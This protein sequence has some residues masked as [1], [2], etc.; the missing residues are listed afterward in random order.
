MQNQKDTKK[1]IYMKLS[2]ILA[3]LLAMIVISLGVI[4][5]SN[6]WNWH[7]VSNFPN[8]DMTDNK[9]LKLLGKV[10]GKSVYKYGI[11]K[12]SYQTFS[13]NKINPEDYF[14]KSWVTVDM[15]TA[16]GL[17]I[18]R[19]GYSVY[20]YE[21]YYVLNTDKA[22]VFCNNDISISEVVDALKNA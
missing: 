1:N 12:M 11:S 14:D 16:S 19:N 3:I 22:L 5:Y 6:Q 13:A 15:L 20:Q 18:L 21:N 10:E 9:S 2:V 4:L 8:V 7:G 17:P